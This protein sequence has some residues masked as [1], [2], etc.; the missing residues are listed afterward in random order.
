DL[1]LFWGDFFSRSL[2]F[3]ENQGNPANPDIH[4]ITDIYPPND[5][6]IFT[7]GYNM[8]RFADIDSDGM[9]DLFVSVLYDP[10]VPQSLMYFRNIGTPEQPA[11]NKVTEDFLYTLDVGNNSHPV[12]IDIDS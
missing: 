9:Y 3:L 8:P 11:Y 1:D 10:T 2:Y 6:S 5:D 12:C 4:L 7:S